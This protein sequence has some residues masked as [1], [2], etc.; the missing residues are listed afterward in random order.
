MSNGQSRELTKDEKMGA[1]RSLAVNVIEKMGNT[2]GMYDI[3]PEFFQQCV[4]EALTTNPAII[5]CTKESFIQS[6]RDCCLAGI[7]PDGRQGAIVPYGNKAKL[8]PMKLGRQQAVHEATGALLKGRAVY[9]ADEFEFEETIVGPPHFRHKQSLTRIDPKEKPIASWAALVP[10]RNEDGSQDPPLIW[11]CTAADIEHARSF[12]RTK[13]D[14]APWKINYAG[15]A[16]KTA[17]NRLISRNEYL[18]RSLAKARGNMAATARMGALLDIEGRDDLPD[19]DDEMIDITPDPEGP[20]VGE[21]DPEPEAPGEKPQAQEEEKPTEQEPPKRGRGRPRGSKNKKTGGEQKPATTA[22][23]PAGDPDDLGQNLPEHLQ[24]QEPGTVEVVD[25][26]TGE[27]TEAEQQ[28]PAFS[29]PPEEED[30]GG[31]DPE[32]D[33]DGD[34]SFLEPDGEDYPTDL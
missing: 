3:A 34:G 17:Q 1:R 30:N 31:E 21:A 11:V 4:A 12:S 8:L 19:G 27:V 23:Q 5:D 6:I 22:G 2:L 14:D 15:M 33:D 10:P 28:Q 18:I 16:E 9:E 20:E 29:L 26:E 32:G 24:D 13:K 25:P 7:I